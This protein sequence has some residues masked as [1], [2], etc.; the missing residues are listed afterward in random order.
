MITLNTLKQVK[1]VEHNRNVSQVLVYK[2]L[3]RFREGNPAA[4]HMGTPLH[5]NTGNVTKVESAVIN[6]IRHQAEITG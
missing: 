4:E 2:L 3:S 6:N 5:R 1:Q